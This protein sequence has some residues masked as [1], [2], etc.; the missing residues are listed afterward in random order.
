LPPE[1]CS[2]LQLHH[3]QERVRHF[4]GRDGDADAGIFECRNLGCCG[5]FAAADNCA[6]MTHAASRRRCGAGDESSH[7]FLAVLF[8]PLGGLFLG[9]TT[10]FTDHDD[11]GGFRVFVEQLDDIEVRRAVNGIATNADARRLANAARGEL[12]NGFVGE[13]AAAGDNADISFLMNVAGRDADA[14]PALRI[15]AFPGRDDAGTVRADEPRG[16]TFHRAFDLYHVVNRN[17]FR[18]GDDE[19]ETGIHALENSVARKGRGNKHRAGSRAGLF[20]GISDGVEDGHFLA[21]MFEEL[22]ALAGR[23][24]G[25]NLRAVINGELS[26]PRA[27]AAGDALNENFGVGFNENG[28]EK[29]VNSDLRISA[30][31]VS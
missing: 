24:T 7:G 18:D 9:T 25:H 13:R 20:H 14:A 21:A 16:F 6:R 30:A 11:A 31:V 23:N 3:F 1:S 26:M 10:N 28:H 19:F 4:A 2:A 12:P 29:F 27:E 15:L 22:S 17:S 5:A 8:D